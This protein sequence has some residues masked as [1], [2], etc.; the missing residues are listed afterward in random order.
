[1]YGLEGRDYYKEMEKRYNT[2]VNVM[3]DLLDC[4]QW[5]IEELF[6]SNNNIEVG[7]IVKEYLEGCGNLPDW[8]MIYKLAF[9][10]FAIDNNLEAEK[11][12]DIYINGCMDTYIYVREDLDKDIVEK[13]EDLFNMEANILP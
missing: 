5:D 6:D 8:K 9:F 2:L 4:G 11:D 1:M 7:Q 10:D 3:S 12:I 13:F